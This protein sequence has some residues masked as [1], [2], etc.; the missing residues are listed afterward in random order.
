MKN[1]NK[2]TVE[3][4][5]VHYDLAKA[6]QMHFIRNVLA[7][8]PFFGKIYKYEDVR[9]PKYVCIKLPTV[10]KQ[11]DEDGEFV[12]WLITMENKRLFKWGTK[13]VQQAVYKKDP[14]SINN[15]IE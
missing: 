4:I 2:R 7:P 10:T 5:K 6:Y 8:N 11:Y 12:G 1:K 15:K 3:E 9:V 14:L 13:I